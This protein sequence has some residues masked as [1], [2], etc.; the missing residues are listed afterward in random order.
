MS[1]PR[2]SKHSDDHVSD[3]VTSI[4]V[5]INESSHIGS[6]GRGLWVSETLNKCILVWPIGLIPSKFFGVQSLL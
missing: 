2:Q 1:S 5:Y 3:N 4:V 6:M